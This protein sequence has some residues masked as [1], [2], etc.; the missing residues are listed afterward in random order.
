MKINTFFSYFILKTLKC[1]F[2][3]FFFNKSSFVRSSLFPGQFMSWHFKLLGRRHCNDLF[4]MDLIQKGIKSNCSSFRT[5]DKNCVSF[6]KLIKKLEHVS[7]YMC[8]FLYC[9]MLLVSFLYILLHIFVASMPAFCC[10][11]HLL[12]IV[13]LK[14]THSL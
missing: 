6:V 10:A 9:K 13:L 12:S 7:I 5:L 1:F 8:F 14:T 4:K 3:F 11:K 2:F